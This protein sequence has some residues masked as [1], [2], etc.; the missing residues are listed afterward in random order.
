MDEL[1]LQAAAF[2]SWDRDPAS[3]S[4]FSSTS[5]VNMLQRK[6]QT[7]KY[8]YIIHNYHPINQK[9]LPNKMSPLKISDKFQSTF[10]CNNNT[11]PARDI[12]LNQNSDVVI[13]R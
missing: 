7:S 11:K 9:H 10:G 1:R 4:A 5:D 8:P 2:A 12:T 13:S 6:L 3:P